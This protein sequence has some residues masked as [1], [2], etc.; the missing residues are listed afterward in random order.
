MALKTALNMLNGGKPAKKTF[1]EE[2]CD[3][4]VKAAKPAKKPVEPEPEEGEE[5]K[6]TSSI[7]KAKYKDKYKPTDM[8]CGDDLATQIREHI[9]EYSTDGKTEVVNKTKL[10]KFA[11]ANGCWDPRYENLNVGQQRMNIG[12]R[13]RAKVRKGH[14]V[15]W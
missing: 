2:V 10:K 6:K 12:N 9:V 14:E 4:A 15:K 5:E 13:L 7:I 1:A 11:Q 3:N 8:T